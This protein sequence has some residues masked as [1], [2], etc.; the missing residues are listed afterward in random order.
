MGNH[1]PDDHD[2]HD[3]DDGKAAATRTRHV[4]ANLEP[5]VIAQLSFAMQRTPTPSPWPS[6]SPSPSPA[7]HLVKLSP[8]LHLLSPLSRR[9]HGPAMLLL[10]ADHADQLTVASGVPSSMVKWAEEGYVVAEIQASALKM[11]GA[12]CIG[13]ALA[14]IKGSAACSSSKVGLVGTVDP[15]TAIIP[16]NKCRVSSA[17]DDP[18]AFWSP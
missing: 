4:T 2:D 13:S 8:G 3:N 1:K 16:A 11:A 15:S 12:E 5:N 7:V 17:D 9:G 10:T 6:P 14:A 18:C